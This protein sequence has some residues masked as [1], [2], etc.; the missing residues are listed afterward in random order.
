M[1]TNFRLKW[2]KSNDS[3][4]LIALAFLNVVEYHNSHFKRY[5]CHD[6]ATLCKNL[7]NFS[8]VTPEFKR[9]KD[10]HCTPHADRQFGYVAWWRHC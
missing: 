8:P 7:V 5:I 4:S 6:L 1:A 3:P 10:V 9:G 2:A